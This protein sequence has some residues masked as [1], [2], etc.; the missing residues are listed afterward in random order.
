M[1]ES[2][3][4]MFRIDETTFKWGSAFYNHIFG[5]RRFYL[6]EDVPPPEAQMKQLLQ[7]GDPDWFHDV[8]TAFEAS[9]NVTHHLTNRIYF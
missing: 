4:K 8:R 7:K 5:L 1:S 3:R 6:K 9:K 2:E